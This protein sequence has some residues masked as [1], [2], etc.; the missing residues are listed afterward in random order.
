MMPPWV[1]NLYE[2]CKQ[3]RRCTRYLIAVLLTPG[4][5]EEAGAL[6]QQGCL[7]VM[8]HLRILLGYRGAIDL[9]RHSS[10]A[11]VLWFLPYYREHVEH[12]LSCTLRE[13]TVAFCS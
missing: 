13:C 8:F 10:H 2:Q 1:N 9:K 5:S 4:F 7:V 3:R 12:A 6:E 11:I